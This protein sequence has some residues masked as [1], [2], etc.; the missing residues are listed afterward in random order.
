MFFDTDEFLVSAEGDRLT[1]EH[2]VKERILTT[3]SPLY[4]GVWLQNLFRCD[5]RFWVDRDRLKHG[6][7]WGKPILG[8]TSV[9]PEF[10]NHNHHVLSGD[11]SPHSISNWLFLLHLNLLVPQQRIEANLRKLK[12]FGIVAREAELA[13]IL[14]IN[15]EAFRGNARNWIQEIKNLAAKGNEH[16]SQK[17]PTGSIEILDDGSIQFSDASQRQLWN[18]FAADTRSTDE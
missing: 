10:V 15:A 12:A 16:P 14:T 2:F 6:L 7:L 3:N 1:P 17:L 9:L 11:G 5:R 8:K 18:Q 13:D 4:F